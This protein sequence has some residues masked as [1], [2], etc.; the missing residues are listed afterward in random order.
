MGFLDKAKKAAEQAQKKLDDVQRDLNASP[1]GGAGPASGVEYD[2]HGRP[3]RSEAAAPPPLPA[4]DAAPSGGIPDV[5]RDEYAAP[6]VSSG[7]PLAG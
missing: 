1:G 6:Q 7:D 3:I 4:P 5:P 2:Q